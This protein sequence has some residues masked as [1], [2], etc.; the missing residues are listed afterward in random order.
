M[1][2]EDFKKNISNSIREIQDNTGKE[3]EALKRKHKN[4]LEN[5]RKIVKFKNSLISQNSLI[6]K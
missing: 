6:Y 5:Y 3:V 2:I 4:P 1:M